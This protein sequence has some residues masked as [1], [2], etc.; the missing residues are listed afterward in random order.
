MYKQH[1]NII[2]NSLYFTYLLNGIFFFCYESRPDS[3]DFFFF[4]NLK[5]NKINAKKK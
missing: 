2:L 1:Q 5:I 3:D 4:F